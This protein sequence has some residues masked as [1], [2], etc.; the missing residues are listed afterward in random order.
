VSRVV[1]AVETLS[2]S[3]SL[4][5]SIAAMPPIAVR[6]AIAAIDL[7]HETT[8]VEGVARERRAFA[9]LFDTPDQK[10]GMHA[11]LERRSPR[12]TG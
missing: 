4:A 9:D 3:L 12:W 1:P 10:E 8:L 6:A 11:F 5:S 7:A 2:A